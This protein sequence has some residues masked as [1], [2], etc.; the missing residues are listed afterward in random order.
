MLQ[1]EDQAVDV[2]VVLLVSLVCHTDVESLEVR[3]VWE[4]IL[5]HAHG[6][7]LLEVLC[8]IYIDA[9]DPGF[10]PEVLARRPFGVLGLRP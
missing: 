3:A 6:P 5:G 7:E 1:I 4:P 10:G 8:A 2:Q 9:Q